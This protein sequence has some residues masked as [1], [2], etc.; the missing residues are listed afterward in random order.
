M[1]KYL[2]YGKEHKFVPAK[3]VEQTFPK[4]SG[5]FVLRFGEENLTENGA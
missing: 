1:E 5:M 2:K 4:V 3:V